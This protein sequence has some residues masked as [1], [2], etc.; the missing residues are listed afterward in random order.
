MLT[1]KLKIR[2]QVPGLRLVQDSGLRHGAASMARL[3]SIQPQSVPF[4]Y[5]EHP[6]RCETR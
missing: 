1:K 2:K 5:A 6:E 4:F 3:C